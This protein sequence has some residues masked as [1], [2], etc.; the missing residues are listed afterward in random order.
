MDRCHGTHQKRGDDSLPIRH[1]QYLERL[2]GVGGEL[3]YNTTKSAIGGAQTAHAPSY[4]PALA[5]ALD[6]IG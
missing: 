2:R 5:L 3:V 1:G 6:A 4:T